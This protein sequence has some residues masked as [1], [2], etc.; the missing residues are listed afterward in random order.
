[1]HVLGIGF[2]VAHDSNV[3]LV[4]DEGIEFA[5]SEER[6]SRRKRD[7]SFPTRSLGQVLS[8]YGQ[9]DYIVAAYNDKQKYA[10]AHR[11]IRDG[12]RVSRF[13]Q[14]QRVHEKILRDAGVTEFFGHHFC[15]AAGAL[16]TSGFADATVITY[17]G[18]IVCEPWLATIWKA[19]NYVLKPIRFLTRLD[20]A[21]AAIRYSAVTS[22][23][24]LRPVHDEGKVTG[25]AACG[26]SNQDCIGE[27]A[28]AFQQQ[29]DPTVYYNGGFRNEYSAIPKKYS[30]AD[31]AASIQ[32]MTEASIIE[33]LSENISEPSATNLVL[34][35]GLFANVLLNFKLKKLGFRGIYVFPAMGDEGLGAGAALAHAVSLGCSPR[36][37][38]NIYL[39]PSYTDLEVLNVLNRSGLQFER[40]EDIEFRTAELL[41]ARMVV[42]RFH[43]S[44]EFGP[45]ALGN[46]SILYQANDVTVNSWL[47]ARLG[48]TETMPFAPVTLSMFADDMY[49]ELNGLERCTPFMTTVVPCK[50]QMRSLSPAVVHVDGTA[51]PQVVSAET[52]PSLHKIL[53]EYCSLTGTP[54]LINTSFNM[55]DEPIV[56]SPEDAV[57]CFMKAQLDY[58]AIDNYLVHH[59]L[60]DSISH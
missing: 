6:F 26:E 15:H 53:L 19:E 10:E 5:C 52:N 40:C 17:D 51:R 4:S 54:S 23:L 28:R 9:P 30:T 21:T 7:G 27:L 1:V 45:R 31:I 18:G 33:L 46:R 60:L 49:S 14:L 25:L 58:L 56:C 44:M 39:G 43:G 59:P 47:N 36:K 24:G 37:L 8:T 12:S 48:R 34:A 20:G 55:H 13:G 38:E 42:G 41:A 2:F 11:D 57:R 35:G 32:E 29:P 22:L 16:F 3:A 50:N